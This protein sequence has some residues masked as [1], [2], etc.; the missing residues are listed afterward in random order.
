MIVHP[1][2][3]RRERLPGAQANG[4]FGIAAAIDCH[5]TEAA[6]RVIRRGFAVKL[7]VSDHMFE[8][9]SLDFFLTLVRLTA[10]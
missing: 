5:R 6:I 2:G 1:V 8:R 7:R 4:T 9:S 10:S 3:V